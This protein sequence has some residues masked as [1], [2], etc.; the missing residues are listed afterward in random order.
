MKKQKSISLNE[1]RRKQEKQELDEKRLAMENRRRAAKGQAP[2]KTWRE[3]EDKADADAEA[4]PDP[5]KEKPED[6]AFA[7]EAGRVLLD[8]IN[9]QIGKR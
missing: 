1:A 6:E 5:D 2:V 8:S 3:V 9:P 7:L 4:G